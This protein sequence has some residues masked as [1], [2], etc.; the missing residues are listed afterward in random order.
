MKL[1]NLFILFLILACSCS[2]QGG[3]GIVDEN[4]VKEFTVNLIPTKFSEN[5]L[6]PTDATILNDSLI[7]IYEPKLDKNFVQIYNRKTYELID[8]SFSK[9]LGP[10][11][12][13]NPLFLAD[14][15]LKYPGKVGLS[16]TRNLN[17][18][19]Y[20]DSQ[21][22]L[23]DSYEMP[24][25][26]RL[27]NYYLLNND[28]VFVGSQTIEH[29]ITVYDKRTGEVRYIDNLPEF[30]D[31]GE[32]DFIRTMQVY[33]SSLTSAGD[34]VALG[35]ERWKVLDIVNVGTGLLENRILFPD[36]LHNENL[37]SLNDRGNMSRDPDM[38]YYFTR[39]RSTPDYIFALCINGTEDEINNGGSS[40]PVLYKFDWDGN[41]ISK[42]LFDRKILNFVL[43]DN[44]IKYVI[45]RGDDGE[46][47]VMECEIL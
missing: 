37:M 14:Y 10:D 33:N 23:S 21:L 44:E 41:V 40:L 9:G 7:A 29:Q 1:R 39:L 36:Y 47:H 12:F 38:E 2:K 25:D 27:V 22:V 46:F 31:Y 3:N 11:E 17:L 28:S 4:D 24:S 26:L 15:A 8:T 43:G 16:G 20:V 32:D 6:Y 34:K 45:A 19:E 13:D 18:Y 30:H 42:Y 35:Y 5:T